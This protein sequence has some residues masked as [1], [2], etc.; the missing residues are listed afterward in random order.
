MF[1]IKEGKLLLVELLQALLQELGK[2]LQ[3]GVTGHTLIICVV[4]A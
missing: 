1:F 3:E 2:L 4:M